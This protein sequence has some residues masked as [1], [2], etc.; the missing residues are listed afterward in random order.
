MVKPVKPAI[1]KIIF[2]VLQSV[3]NFFY[4]VTDSN[5]DI[6]MINIVH[7]ISD[8][9]IFGKIIVNNKPVKLQIDSGAS[10][11]V[12][13]EQYVSPADI[14]T[15]TTVLQ[16]YTKSVVKP[17]GESKVKIYNHVNGHTYSVKFVI[18]PKNSGLIAI[19]G[20]KA[21]QFM[22][23]LTLNTNN[24]E[25]VL[26]LKLS[27]VIDDY[28]DVFK[29]ELGQLSG[30]AHFLTDPSVT[31]VVSPV[32]RIPVSLT[33]KVKHELDHLSAKNVITPVQQPTDWVSNLVVTMQ[34]SGDLRVC[35]DP[36]EL[37]KALKRE[38]FQLPTLD[39]ILPNLSNAKLFSTVDIRSAY[40]HVLLDEE[41]SL[42]TTFSTPYGKYRWV[43]MP[44]GC[45]VSSEIFQKKLFQCLYGFTR[46]HCVADDIM[47]T[48]RGETEKDALIDHDNNLIALMKRCRD[49]G[50]R[51]NP[52]KMILRQNHVPFYAI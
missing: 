52:D 30:K 29:D 45:N 6:L 5:G 43:R 35:L 4:S 38:H 10:V 40:W 21:S 16:M 24:L 9:A 44:F 11:N 34:K 49:V 36:Q 27:N 22:N 3:I 33:V 42:L 2:P 23:I 47:I 51:L 28:P 20:S 19:L 41:S 50:I 15:T 31:P 32:R 18:I 25:P 39:D 37:N 12:L 8:K 7:I 14:Q 26:Q 13:P 17:L 46:I 48:G 1:R